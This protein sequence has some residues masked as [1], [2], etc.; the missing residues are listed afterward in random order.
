MLALTAASTCSAKSSGLGAPA[1]P[2][3]IMDVVCVHRTQRHALQ[4]RDLPLHRAKVFAPD[5]L[6]ALLRKMPRQAKSAVAAQST[7]SADRATCQRLRRANRMRPRQLSRSRSVSAHSAGGEWP[8][9]AAA[10]RSGLLML[11][12]QRGGR[13]PPLCVP[14][15]QAPQ[16]LLLYFNLKHSDVVIRRGKTRNP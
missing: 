7:A 16:G 15:A 13:L 6:T 3:F 5:A 14:C 12:G 10:S 8:W 4:H 9:R 11:V 1:A 2:L